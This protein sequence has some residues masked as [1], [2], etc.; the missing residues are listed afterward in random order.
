VSLSIACIHCG[1]LSETGIC[2]PCSVPV[3]VEYVPTKTNKARS[4]KQEK[5]IATSFGGRVQPASGALAGAKGDV[6]VRG[7]LRMEM[8]LT[9]KKAYRVS[10]EDLVKIRSECGLG[11]QPVFCVDFV[12][13][14][15]G[16]TK[17]SWALIPMAFFEELHENKV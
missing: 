17:D 10:Y 6:R 9:S 5:R 14:N 7:K 8:K 12:D 2:G 4:K 3:A 13:G 1:A 16:R 11:E 15:T